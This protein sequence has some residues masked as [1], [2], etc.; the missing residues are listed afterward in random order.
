MEFPNAT[1]PHFEVRGF[2]SND[3]SKATQISY[4]PLVNDKEQ[5]SQYVAANK[6]WFD[7]SMKMQAELAALHKDEGEDHRR[8]A[9]GVAVSEIPLNLWRRAESTGTNESG[10]YFGPGK[11]GPVWQQA[12]APA[13]PAS[14]INFDL[15]SLEPFARV[16][17]GMWE[18]RLP[19]LS[20]VMNLEWLYGSAVKDDSEHPHSFLMSP[21]Y[22]SL[23][24]GLHESDDLAGLLLAVVDWD[25]YFANL[26]VEGTNGIVV[27]LHDTCGDHF[28]YELHG[29]KAVFIGEGD[30]HD[31]AYNHLEFDTEFAPFLHHNFSETLEHC[32][33]DLRI[34]P[35][36]TL[37]SAYRTERPG[38]YTAVVVLV[39]F[40]TAMVFV[41]Y[42]YLVQRRQEKVMAT[43]K[44]T[45][46][47]VSSLFPKNVRDRIMKDAAEQ[48][49]QDLKD[50]KKSIFGM[51]DR[52]GAKTKL[53]AFLDEELEGET[54]PGGELD[55]KP[56]ADLFPEVTIMFADI[57]GFTAWSSVREPAQVFTLLET[58]F[59][60]F[61]EIASRRRVFK[62]ETVGDCYVAVAGLPDPRKDHAVVMAV[63]FVGSY[64]PHLESVR[65]L[66]NIPFVVLFF[67]VLPVMFSIG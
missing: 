57:V 63:S 16:Y 67:S 7:E 29:P 33:Y 46:A 39:F 56:I 51:G 48:A 20:E 64:T 31:H 61:D 49:E 52:A 1:I 65:D 8:L 5:W 40:F 9:E 62:V 44:R 21:V 22:P 47:I 24:A 18:S 42:D 25:H 38:I 66:S 28:T 32:E 23:K 3:L 36:A 54:K 26:L 4:V 59:A 43:A 15:F 37:E 41:L 58:L 55:S 50:N 12:P 34:F 45:N 60:A 13:D 27:V 2:K 53:K 14:I 19:V 6:G 17:H 10:A 11:F 35:S 30:L